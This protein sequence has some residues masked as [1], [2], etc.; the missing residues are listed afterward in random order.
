[1]MY[2]SF[3]VEQKKLLVGG[4]KNAPPYVYENQEGKPEGFSID[5]IKRVL[6][7]LNAPYEISF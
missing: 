7:W 3:A 1:M 6:D 2:E 4:F 5:F